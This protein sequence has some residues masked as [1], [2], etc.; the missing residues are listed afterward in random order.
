VIIH[1]GID[2]LSAQEDDELDQLDE[3]EGVTLNSRLGCQ[4]KVY[5]DVD[6]EIPPSGQA[7]GREDHSPA[8]TLRP[9]SR[10]GTENG[11]D[12]AG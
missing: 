3:A 4:A 7:W 8:V 5:G 10:E 12:V 11:S 9:Y 2:H 1:R 6:V